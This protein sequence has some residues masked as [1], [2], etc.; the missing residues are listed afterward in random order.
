MKVLVTGANGFVGRN[1]LVH[2]G[3]R[4]DIEVV[5]FTREHALESLPE[6]VRDVDFVFHLAGINR[7]K[8]PEEFKVGNAD[9]TLELCRAIKAPGRQIPVLYTSS[10]QAEL[11]NAYGASKR[12][13]EEA[14]SELQSQHGSA[15][16]LFRLP[17]VF[18]KWA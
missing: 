12:G 2:L 16:H 11:D 3:E 4:K 5:L 17:N 15:V 1:L 8:D 13:A 9:L 18:G 6:K 14:L 7:P 10:S